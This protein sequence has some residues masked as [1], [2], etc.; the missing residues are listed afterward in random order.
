LLRGGGYRRVVLIT[1]ARVMRIGAG[2][3]AD[4]E[5]TV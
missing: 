4:L 5:G 3:R 1:F 2:M